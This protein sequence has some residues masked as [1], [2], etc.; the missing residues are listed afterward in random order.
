MFEPS[1]AT[2]S[3][4]DPLA[5][6][7]NMCW[8]DS[9]QLENNRFRERIDPEHLPVQRIP[10]SFAV[11]TCMD[12]RV[13]LE[14]IGIFPFSET[15]SG[16]SA[17]RVMRTIGAMADQRSLVV[18]IFLAGVREIAVVMHTDCGCC[19][20]FSKIDVI[21]DNLQNNLATDQFQEFKNT[22]GEPFTENL[23]TWLKAFETPKDAVKRE[24]ATIRSYPF[25]PKTVILHGLVYEISTG[26]VEVV[27]NGYDEQKIAPAEKTS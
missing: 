13:N 24:I 3:K 6:E 12:P 1:A 9:L 20:A 19:H 22:I 10:S 2:P 15:G 14:A 18:G 27:V 11:I 4:K 17:V 5:C 23:R 25:V 16:R 7:V 8:L 21:V 26:K